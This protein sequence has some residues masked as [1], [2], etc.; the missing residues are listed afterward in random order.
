MLGYGYI[1]RGYG[2]T[3]FVFKA[4]FF[5]MIFSVI[6]GY[7]LIKQFGYLGAATTILIRP[8][9]IKALLPRPATITTVPRIKAVVKLSAIGE[10][11]KA[12]TKLHH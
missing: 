5:K 10:R 3:E 12:I 1:L 2:K 6:I 9:T 11:K 4:N 8:G 7:I